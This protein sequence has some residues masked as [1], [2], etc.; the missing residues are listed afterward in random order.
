MSFEMDLMQNGALRGALYTNENNETWH[1]LCSELN[2]NI[3]LVIHV[4]YCMLFLL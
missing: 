3:Q 1:F 2:R 4:K